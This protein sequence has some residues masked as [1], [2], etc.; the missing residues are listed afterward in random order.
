MAE[1]KNINING[2]IGDTI[3]LTAGSVAGWRYA[4]VNCK[5]GDDFTINGLGGVNPR[6]WAFLDENNKLL[7]RS[8]KTSSADDLVITA[9]KGSAKLII[10]STSNKPC[11][12]GI[13]N[14]IK[15]DRT[16]SKLTDGYTLDLVNSLYASDGTI[17]TNI[18]I[19][20]VV[21]IAINDVDGYINIV[22][23]CKEGDKFKI[24]GVGGQNARLWA[25]VNENNKLLSIQTTNI[26][27]KTNTEIIAPKNSAKIIVN[28]N[29]NEGNPKELYLYNPNNIEKINIIQGEN[30]LEKYSQKGNITT[31]VD[32]GS[33]I[34]LNPSNIANFICAV[35]PCRPGQSFR[36]RGTGG[37]NPKLWAFLD[38]ENKLL[39]KQ[40]DL[41]LYAEQDVTITAPKG[42]YILIANFYIPDDSYNAELYNY[43]EETIKNNNDKIEKINLED[44]TLVTI[45]E[46]DITAL[47]NGIKFGSELDNHLTDFAKPGDKMVHVSTFCIINDVIYVT[48]YANTIHA[49][50]QPAEHTA[51]FAYCNLNDLDN[52]TFIDLQ[53]IGETVNGKKV[54]AI[55]D[56]ILLK[57]D[58]DTLFLM[59]TAKLDNTYYR[60]YRTYT[61]S[62]NT[63]SD[64]AIN[65]FK[66]NN[67]VGDFCTSDMK[68]AFAAN[69]IDFKNFN[70]PFGTDIGIMQKLTARVENGITYYYTGAYIRPFNC[71]IKSADLITWEFVAQPSFIN[72]SEWENATYV[73]DDRCFYFMRQ[74][75]DNNTGI[76]TSY[77][78]NTQQWE[79]KVYINDCQSRSDFFEYNGKLYLIHAPKD[80]NHLSILEVNQTN[81]NR[82]TEIQTAKISDYFYPFV[83]VYNNELYVSFTQSRK[84]IWLSKFSLRTITTVEI[85]NKIKQ[86][87]QI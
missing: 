28:L 8:V 85:M 52:K 49:V 20:E 70:Q 54:T 3:D 67:T 86:L 18:N 81:L 69:D 22:K 26:G 59:W 16:I 50:E 29:T 75:A 62:T 57:K 1:N 68:S 39:V 61:I 7:A 13:S 23:D 51:R 55:Y 63:L 17:N 30:L 76:L 37:S 60:L 71:I 84:H 48:Y 53:N 82:S 80:R 87:F 27:Y 14:S 41:G 10:N 33:I 4:I 9:P 21:D 12:R 79:K 32:F 47:A 11:Y 56:T 43:S 35:I 34:S 73:K 83:Q 19:G 44:N 2:N 6:L 65:K 31:N 46:D 58:D 78:L 64:I 36:V 5:E 15:I 74:S 40:E 42:A 45:L 66:V 38:K 77:N 72:N 24:N 25:F